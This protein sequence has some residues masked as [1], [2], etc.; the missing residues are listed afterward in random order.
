MSVYVKR[1]CTYCGHTLEEWIRS[2]RSIGTPLKKCDNCGKYNRITHITEWDLMTPMK[3][4]IWLFDIWT[5]FMFVF[6]GSIPLV[7]IAEYIGININDAQFDKIIITLVIIRYIIL[8]MA[9]RR[10][11][12]RM[13]D[14]KYRFFLRKHRVYELK[15]YYM[16]R[17]SYKYDGNKNDFG[18]LFDNNGILI[19]EGKLKNGI[20]DGYG[21]EYTIERNYVYEGNFKNGKY[22]GKG[23][24]YENYDSS[25]EGEFFNGVLIKK[26]N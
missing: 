18:G 20:P 8:F 2:Y 10:S 19:Y 5:V 15:R 22:S 16:K 17:S 3:K 1:K 9:I 21:I 11:K 6:V 14:E 23:I 7:L 4:I 12:K 24:L 26:I 13:K 25:I